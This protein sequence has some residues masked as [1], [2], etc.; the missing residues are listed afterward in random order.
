MWVFL[1]KGAKMRGP[2]GPAL[3]SEPNFIFFL[4]FFKGKDDLLSA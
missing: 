1:K 4:L 3:V 2:S